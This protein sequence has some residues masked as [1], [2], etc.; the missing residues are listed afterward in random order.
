MPE[1]GVP[2]TPSAKLLS[3]DEI[4]RVARIFADQG[5]N[6]VIKNT[7]KFG[8]FEGNCDDENSNT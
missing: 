5:V 7:N 2:L 3:A 4:T 8:E 6:K 1:E